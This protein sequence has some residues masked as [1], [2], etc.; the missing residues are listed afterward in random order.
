MAAARAGARKLGG[1]A[2]WPPPATAAVDRSPL[3]LL[4]P[5]HSQVSSP[6]SSPV[7]FERRLGDGRLCK[8]WTSR[9]LNGS[10]PCDPAPCLFAL[11]MRKNHSVA[12]ALANGR[13]VKWLERRLTSPADLDAFVLLWGKV[14]QVN[15]NAEHDRIDWRW[16]ALF[17]LG[18]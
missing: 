1:V 12:D 16:T 3:A 17:R 18:I 2:L 11:A 14:Q 5:L 6:S 9:W 8:F 13:W 4:R 10:A 15:L 7:G